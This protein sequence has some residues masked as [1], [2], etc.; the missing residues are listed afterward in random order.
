MYLTPFHFRVGSNYPFLG[1]FFLFGPGGPRV[2]LGET[3]VVTRSPA[4]EVTLGN[5]YRVRTKPLVRRTLR[6]R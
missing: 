3:S 4:A 6:V 5:G 2:H 1:T